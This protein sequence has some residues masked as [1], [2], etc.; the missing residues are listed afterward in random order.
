MQTMS[1]LFTLRPARV[2][3]M[4]WLNAYCAAEGMAN[5]DDSVDVTVAVN[6]ADEPVGFIQ[7]AYG[8]RGVAHIYPIVVHPSWRGFDV[9]RT[10]IEDAHAH[11]GEL[12]LVSRG[13]SIG[14]YERL[15]FVECPWDAI[16]NEL[17]EG[18]VDCPMA[19]ECHPLPMW[20]L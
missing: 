5:L 9:G 19:D 14:F 7:I 2:D 13:S 12:R 20:L 11:H 6:D 4:P 18:C 15:G 16:D 1:E 8:S 17:T 3:D 10:L